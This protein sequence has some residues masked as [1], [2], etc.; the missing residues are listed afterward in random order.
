MVIKKIDL[1]SDRFAEQKIVIQLNYSELTKIA[2]AVHNIKVK[3]KDDAWLKWEF[4]ALRDLCHD[5][6]F[7]TDFAPATIFPRI[8]KELNAV[9]KKNSKKNEVNNE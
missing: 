1:T 6:G 2:N 5:E 3:D 8:M 4:A 7:M 9:E